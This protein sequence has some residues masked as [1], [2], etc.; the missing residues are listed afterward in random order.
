VRAYPSPEKRSGYTSAKKSRPMIAKMY[1]ISI[2]RSTID[3]MA[4]IEVRSVLTITWPISE[5]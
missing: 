2:R 1:R 5:E 4:G 3:P